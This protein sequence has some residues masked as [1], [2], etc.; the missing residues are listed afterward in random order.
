MFCYIDCTVLPYPEWLPPAAALRT[1]GCGTCH[2]GFASASATRGHNRAKNHDQKSLWF[3]Q[4][5]VEV[6]M[7]D[8]ITSVAAG[9]SHTLCVT[10]GGEVWA[11]GSN[12]DGQLGISGQ[13]KERV[14]VSCASIA[15]ACLWVALDLLCSFTVE[16]RMAMAVLIARPQRAA[17]SWIFAKQQHPIRLLS[18]IVCLVRYRLVLLALITYISSAL[19]SLV[20]LP[21]GL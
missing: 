10:P 6:P 4:V 17:R 20:P 16:Q 9:E 11:F 21:A 7:P 2:T 15:R 1:W 19:L 5:P 12:N 3:L 14:S 13:L 8:F 18:H